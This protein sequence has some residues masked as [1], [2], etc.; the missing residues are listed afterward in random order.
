M[1]CVFAPDGE[2]LN[3]VLICYATPP[4]RCSGSERYKDRVRFTD[5]S[6][7]EIKDVQPDDSGIFKCETVFTPSIIL[8]SGIIIVGRLYFVY[9]FNL[10]NF[11]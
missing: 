5:T 8:L 6:T 2:W 11:T 3:E 4:N 1:S 7:L 10:I 9:F